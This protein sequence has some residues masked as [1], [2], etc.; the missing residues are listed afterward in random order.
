MCIGRQGQGSTQSCCRVA[1]DQQSRLGLVVVRGLHNVVGMPDRFKG[2]ACNDAT[3]AREG[4]SVC[5]CGGLF[6]IPG[7]PAFGA[8][9]TTLSPF[10]FLPVGKISTLYH[11]LF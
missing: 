10:P 3:G 11:P 2:T 7:K 6:A 8:R 9:A 4:Q 5:V 1:N